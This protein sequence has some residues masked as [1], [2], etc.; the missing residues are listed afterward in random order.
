[1]TNDRNATGDTQNECSCCQRTLR[2]DETAA[3]KAC[4]EKM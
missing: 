3:C 2:A 4:G 1:M